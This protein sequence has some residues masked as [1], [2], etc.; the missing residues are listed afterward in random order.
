ME[1]DLDPDP[2]GLIVLNEV[3]GGD[4]SDFYDQYIEGAGDPDGTLALAAI[5]FEMDGPRV[6]EV[7]E[8][9]ELQLAT[10]EDFFT[11]D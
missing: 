10:R 9:T 3:A 5:G 1:L 11:I 6:V 2:D 8:P 4:V 7:E